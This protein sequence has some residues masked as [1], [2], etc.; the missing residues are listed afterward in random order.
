MSLRAPCTTGRHV[1]HTRTCQSGR[2]SIGSNDSHCL[3]WSQLQVCV[4]SQEGD[5]HKT[6][7]LARQEIVPPVLQNTDSMQGPSNQWHSGN[8]QVWHTSLLLIHVVTTD[9]WPN[10]T[11]GQYSIESADSDRSPGSSC[12]K[13][14]CEQLVAKLVLSSYLC[15]VTCQHQNDLPEAVN[16]PVYHG[17][18]P[19]CMLTP[20]QISSKMICSDLL[21]KP[22]DQE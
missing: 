13:L 20:D 18:E 22:L 11:S 3:T 19:S 1:A 6:F 5:A 12:N 15:A 14:L 4:A 21:E 16:L 2:Q 7:A 9:Q 8:S 17:F 10:I